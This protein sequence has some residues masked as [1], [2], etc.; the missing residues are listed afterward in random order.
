MEGE[1]GAG[2]F[3][4]GRAGVAERSRGGACLRTCFAALGA[5]FCWSV[6]DSRVF[7]SD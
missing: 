2:A 3:R 4:T 5:G 1:A 6:Q 7:D